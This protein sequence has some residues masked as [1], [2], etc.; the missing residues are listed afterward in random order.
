MRTVIH[1]ITLVLPSERDVSQYEFAV[2]PS[3]VHIA[4]SPIYS[5]FGPRAAGYF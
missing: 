1:S 4:L 2:K 5:E 3:R